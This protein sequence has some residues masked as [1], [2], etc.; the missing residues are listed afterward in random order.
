MNIAFLYADK[1]RERVLAEA[2]VGGLRRHGVDAKTVV[3]ASKSAVPL[4][5]DAAC[6]FGVK[7][8]EVWQRYRRAGIHVFYF[9]KGYVRRNQ[10]FWRVSI[11]SHNPTSWLMELDQPPDRF[12]ALRLIVKPWR[13]EGDQVVIAGSSAKYHAF[14]GLLEPTEFATRLVKRIGKWTNGRQIVYRPKPSWRDAVPID[15]TRFSAAPRTIEDELSGAHALVT[16]GSNACFEAM[17]SGIPTIALGDAIARPISSTDLVD[18]E[19]PRV[20]SDGE[21]LRLLSDLAYFQWTRPEMA[22]GQAWEFLR[23]L[24]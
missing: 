17:L 16:H 10:E 13:Q 4:E 8:R 20:A 11:N 5:V 7:S 2:F 1:A 12:R 23:R 22:S 18:I 6:M 24:M 19:N 3:L 15:G 14:H 9:D 21:R